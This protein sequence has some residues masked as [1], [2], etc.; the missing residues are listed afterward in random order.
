MKRSQQFV[1]KTRNGP[2][3]DKK[4]KKIHAAI[5]SPMKKMHTRSLWA[6]QQEEENPACYVYFSI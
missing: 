4:K 2:V 3:E 1:E 6:I 5:F